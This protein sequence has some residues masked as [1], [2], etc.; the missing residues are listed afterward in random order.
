[1]TITFRV[2][3]AA[4]AL[5]TLL[6]MLFKIRKSRMMVSYAVFWIIFAVMLIVLSLFPGIAEFASKLLGISSPA[7]LVFAF[8]IFVL[9]MRLFKASVELSVL[10]T[11]VRRLSQKIAL[12][13]NERNR[14]E[15]FDSI[16]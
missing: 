6:Y 15:D 8:I 2:L 16:D 10:D 3:L 13:E 12:D 7:N 5:M 1:M 14:K 11:K 9:L 4:V